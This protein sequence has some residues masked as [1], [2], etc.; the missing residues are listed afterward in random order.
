MASTAERGIPIG[1]EQAAI[2]ATQNSSLMYSFLM[3]KSYD[4]SKQYFVDT[5]TGA[6]SIIFIGTIYVYGAQQKTLYPL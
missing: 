3:G 4:Y 6:Y 2:S 1:K 5:H